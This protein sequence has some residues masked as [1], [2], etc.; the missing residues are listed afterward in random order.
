MKRFLVLSV[1]ICLIM[2]SACGHIQE[3][4]T[5][6]DTT[7]GENIVKIVVPDYSSCLAPTKFF[8]IEDLD[9]YI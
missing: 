6:N 5:P 2:L 8:S 3:T 4:T 7:P 1:F 9:T